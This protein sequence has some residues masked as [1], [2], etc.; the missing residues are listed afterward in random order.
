VDQESGSDGAAASPAP[1][2]A[3]IAEILRGIEGLVGDVVREATD[4]AS[5][6]VTAA[7]RERGN[8]LGSAERE[9]ATLLSQAKAQAG[10]IGAAARARA[11]D[12]AAESERLSHEFLSQMQ[13]LVTRAASEHA[14]D[15]PPAVEPEPPRP[16]P[17]PGAQEPRGFEPPRAGVNL[18][19]RLPIADRTK[20]SGGSSNGQ[21]DRLP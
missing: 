3:R 14:T 9:A 11:G 10:E 15:P 20:G 4:E 8:I 7:R 21:R 19:S 5:R 12:V 2:E 17:Y 1:A 13:A 18:A 6:L 16:Q